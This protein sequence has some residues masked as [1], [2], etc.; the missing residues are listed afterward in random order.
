[1]DTSYNNI[2]LDHFTTKWLPAGIEAAILRLDKLHPGI[3]GNKWFKLKYNIEAAQVANARGIL[4]YG[5]AYSNHIAATA[6]ACMEAHIPCT[7]IIRGEEN[8]AGSNHTLQMAA[9]NGMQLVF[10][11]R[12]EYR[13]RNACT[14]WEAQYPG[15]H[16]IPEGGHNAAG[17]KGCEEI[18]S[19]HSTQSF[20][21]ILCAAGTGT[22]LA[23]LA[24][25]ALPHQQVTGIAV[26]KGAQ[27]L[28][29]EVTNLV[30]PG[31]TDHWQLLYNYHGG[32]YAKTSPQLIDFINSFYAETGIPT[33]IIY[34]G[35]LIMAFHELLSQHHFPDNSKVLLI[36][37][38]GLQGNLSLPSGVLS[39]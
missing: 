3:S 5:G 10:V 27:Y 16:I 20:T 31:H 22:T 8:N 17:A 4:T 13:N 26:L 2:T 30:K 6:V 18:L 25:S 33:D 23:G 28:D 12:E 37:T 21:H 11:S 14:K 1:M 35:K 9:A 32:G 24:N 19:I 15:F 7:G 29:A 38:G 34:T 39:L 36:H